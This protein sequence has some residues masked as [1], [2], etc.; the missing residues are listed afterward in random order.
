MSLIESPNSMSVANYSELKLASSNQVYTAAFLGG[1]LAGGWLL[2]Q[3]LKLI[4]RIQ[5]SKLVL[6]GTFIALLVI[7]I[8]GLFLPSNFPNYI[9]P[10]VIAFI[11]KTLY[12]HIF[13]SN[14]KQHIANN[15]TK[16]SWWKVLGTCIVSLVLTFIFIFSAVFILPI[17]Q[18]NKVEFGQNVIYYEGKANKQDAEMLGVY[19]QKTGV[20]NEDAVWF[21][22][23]EFPKHDSKSFIL[24]IPY[25]QSIEGTPAH[26]ELK[27]LAAL[28]EEKYTNHK[29]E[30]QVQNIYGLT[31]LKVHN[32]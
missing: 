4:G 30:I 11:F 28:I 29:V 10:V 24:K 27:S 7:T 18:N 16:T 17:H 2:F 3:N 14:F 9:I 12:E 20:F 6:F 19:F 8:V 13:Q 1:P 21:I 26:E 5:Q 32:E 23:I 31:V 22:T 25:E 15:G